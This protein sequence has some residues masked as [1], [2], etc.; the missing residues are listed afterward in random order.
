LRRVE[1]DMDDPPYS[2]RIR[3]VE[4]ANGIEHHDHARF[5][6]Y[7]AG[8]LVAGAVALLLFRTVEDTD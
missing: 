8:L 7:L 4:R 3:E 5:W 2:V 1:E 6:L